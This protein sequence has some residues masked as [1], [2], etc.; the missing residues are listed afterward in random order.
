MLEML[1]V[2][3]ASFTWAVSTKRLTDLLS[4]R[5]MDDEHIRWG[6]MRRVDDEGRGDTQMRKAR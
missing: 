1:A 2:S 6:Q 5:N 3:T 4:Q